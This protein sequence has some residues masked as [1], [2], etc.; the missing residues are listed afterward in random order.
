VVESRYRSRPPCSRSL[1]RSITRFAKRHGLDLDP[2][3]RSVL[4]D[5]TGVDAAGRFVSLRGKF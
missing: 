2:W 1:G 4:D 5:F 3:Q